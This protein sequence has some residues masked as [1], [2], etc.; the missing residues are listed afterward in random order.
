M[1][2]VSPKEQ[3][4][5]D[6][7]VELELECEIEDVEA[8]LEEFVRLNHTGQFNDAHEL[9]D[10]C[11]VD[12]VDWFP[13]A[14]E[15]ADCL[16][17]EGKFSQL[18]K[19]LSE[20][21][22]KF[23][24]PG[25]RDLLEAISIAARIGVC[26][27]NKL[28]LR[29]LQRMMLVSPFVRDLNYDSSVK[30][31]EVKW[32]DT[33]CERNG[34]GM[35]C[36]QI[37][38]LQVI[39]LCTSTLRKLLPEEPLL[40]WTLHQSLEQNCQTSCFAL[41]GDGHLWESQRI[42]QSLM[43]CL[44]MSEGMNLVTKY[45]QIIKDKFAGQEAALVALS[46]LVQ[47][48]LYQV[49]GIVSTPLTTLQWNDAVT[50][51]LFDVA[52]VNLAEGSNPPFSWF[53]LRR[54]I[55][56]N[57]AFLLP[58][59]TPP[60]GYEEIDVLVETVEKGDP[61]KL[62]Q[63]LSATTSK[64]D[65]AEV[66]KMAL[67]EAAKKPSN[68]AMD[69]FIDQSTVNATDGFQRTALHLASF[70]TQRQARM[71]KALLKKGANP[72]SMDWFE[73]TALHYAVA[74]PPAMNIAMQI[75]ARSY[76]PHY[77][78]ETES[79]AIIKSLISHDQNLIHKRDAQGLTPLDVANKYGSPIPRNELLQVFSKENDTN[80]AESKDSKSAPSTQRRR[81]HHSL[82]SRISETALSKS[83][84][85]KWPRSVDAGDRELERQT[86]SREETLPAPQ[87]TYSPPPLSGL[88]NQN[89]RD[90]SLPWSPSPVPDRGRGPYL[91][92][93]QLRAAVD[94]GQLRDSTERATP[95]PPPRTQSNLA[96]PT[97]MR[98]R[99]PRWDDPP[100]S[101]RQGREGNLNEFFVDGK[102]IHREIL[103]QEI[104][105]YLGPD[106]YSKPSTYDVHSPASQLNIGRYR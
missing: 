7:D 55:E 94:P 76:D 59:V 36:E 60:R 77:V 19:F 99:S 104:S 62:E 50:W 30:L 21:A 89:P 32:K 34:I 67:I 14:A 97:V 54:L 91:T 105:K 8:E 9:F 70:S 103:Q 86:P 42:L 66:R 58:L 52:V 6:S 72:D 56:D 71:V 98:D 100:S 65:K 92:E 44:P 28:D 61:V 25:D 31:T 57:L 102:G 73:R 20:V 29:A 33:S 39:L 26:Q 35:T 51:A 87:A 15:F 88:A 106:A 11:L 45:I 38:C 18:E 22:T 74:S 64:F 69:Q 24:T 27:S 1:M 90:V 5:G 93:P 2:D 63:A 48:I 47:R 80:I 10:E 82:A 37:H 13:V 49:S 78:L 3:E 83:I 75:S 84:L 43:Y 96:T 12:H 95:S 16:L 41:L 23:P 40:D 85:S 17:R 101:S 68:T 46:S 4:D 81:V 53:C 79:L